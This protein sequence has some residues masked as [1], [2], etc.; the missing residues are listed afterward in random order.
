MQSRAP[1]RG[2]TAAAR[3]S[4]RHSKSL[5][6]VAAMKAWLEAQLTLIPPRS[7]LA[8]AIRYALIRWS[9]LCQLPR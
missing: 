4:V 9:A 6:L 8:D 7:G 5:P 2:Q 1:I 3:Q